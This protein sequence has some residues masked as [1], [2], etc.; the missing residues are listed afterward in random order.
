ME[1]VFESG[2][3]YSPVLLIL[4]VVYT[5]LMGLLGIAAFV[6]RSMGV[7]TLATRRGIKRA[8]FAWIPVLD[9]YLLGCISDQY[10]YVVKG[11]NKAKRNVLLWLNI[12]KLLIGMG[13]G[14]SY[15]WMIIN[16]M[17]NLL[18]G[19]SEELMM[20][21]VMGPAVAIMSLS[22]PLLVMTIPPSR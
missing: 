12:G 16:V 4:Y 11:K 14:G 1:Y 5:L 8:W 20:Q 18:S 6:L 10:Q 17:Q 2:F 15:V 7:Y 9:Q 19:P 22:I 3:E 13:F 21:A